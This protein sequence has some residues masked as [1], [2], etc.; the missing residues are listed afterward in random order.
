MNGNVFCT[1]CGAT[2]A[3]GT[4]F[5]NRCGAAQAGVAAT[6]APLGAPLPP[7]AP[8]ATLATPP[9]YPPAASYPGS[10]AARYGG[11][12]I[13]FIAA[14]IDGIIVNIVLSP[15]SF[16][17]GGFSGIAGSMSG[18]SH[19]G[20]PILG[21]LLGAGIGVFGSWLYEAFMESSS[22]QATLGK[23]IFGMRVTDL[24]G[25]RISFE[26]A[27]GRHFAKYLSLCTL[28]IGYIMAGLTER[29][30][31]LHDMVAGTLV[32]R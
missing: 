9:S 11:F 29:K 8:L 22:H 15:V 28:L 31:A 4:R 32:R 18:I 13:R 21:G 26:R 2:L 24:Q 1:Q 12:W 6:L 30:Q 17:V 5:C 10:A 20:L 19:E 16:M 23:M 3:D 14:I 7:A 25:N 27:T